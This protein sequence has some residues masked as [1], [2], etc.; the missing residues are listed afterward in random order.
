MKICDLKKPAEN[1]DELQIK[2]VKMQRI[3]KYKI[4]RIKLLIPKLFL[5]SIEGQN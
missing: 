5:L 4:R 3:I 2:I 1:V